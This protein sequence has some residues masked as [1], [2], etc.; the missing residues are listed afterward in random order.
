MKK[1]SVIIPT[2]NRSMELKRAVRS[3]LNQTYE[4]FELI[5][6]DD[7]SKDDTREVVDNFE[8]D[9]IRYHKN[10]TNMGGSGSRNVGI[11]MSRNDF[12]AFLDDDDQWFPTK[13]EK[14]VKV[15]KDTPPDYCGV[16]T[17]LI[18]IREGEPI[19]EKMIYKE[20]NLFEDLLWENIIGSTSVI[21]LKKECLLDV[22]GFTKN[23]PASQELD[24]Y[25]RLSERYKFK[26][27]GE[28]LV[29]YHIHNK[30]QI[31]GDYSKK[32]VSKKYIF[33]KYKDYITSSSSLHAR[34][35]YEIGYQQYMNGDKQAGL[36]S[37]KQ[38]FLLSPFGIK[39]LIR[40]ILSKLILGI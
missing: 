16:Y 17:G 3:V 4:D 29:R 40:K 36:D 39:H 18:K 30:N 23:L 2:Y 12:I 37:F 1:V 28:P 8:D 11:R 6:V 31:T 22:G 27:V 20:G 38:A 21:L 10:E 5:I 13:L 24:L 35:L 26:C 9:R 7:N 14:Q 34:H 19:S 15:L 32:I 33:E 25:L